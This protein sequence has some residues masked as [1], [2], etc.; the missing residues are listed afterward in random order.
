MGYSGAQKI[1]YH[2]QTQTILMTGVNE[3]P[4]YQIDSCSFDLST[5]AHLQ[6]H[7]SIITSISDLEEGLVATGDDRGSVRIWDLNKMRCQQVLKIAHTL[8]DLQCFGNNLIYADS[9]LNLL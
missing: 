8:T 1:H 2:R 3:L 5:V 9:R 4:V 7:Q 6:G